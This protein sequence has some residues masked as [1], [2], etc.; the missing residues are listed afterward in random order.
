MLKNSQNPLLFP[1]MSLCECIKENN[2]HLQNNW[3][4]YKYID[5]N[6]ILNNKSLCYTLGNS[7]ICKCQANRHLNKMMKKPW[8]YKSCGKTYINP[9]LPAYLFHRLRGEWWV[10]QVLIALFK[11]LKKCTTFM[12]FGKSISTPYSCFQCNCLVNYKVFQ[13]NGRCN[14]SIQAKL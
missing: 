7:V 14:S 13:Q 3:R 5:F 8:T 2:R 6:K 12:E 11:L 1:K 9:S 10:D 4:K